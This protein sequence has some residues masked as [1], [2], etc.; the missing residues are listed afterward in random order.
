MAQMTRTPKRK[1]GSAKAA[2]KHLARSKAERGK[3]A[4]TRTAPRR[5]SAEAMLSE[6]RRRL[7]EIDDL[8]A[9]A[10]LLGWDQA[11]YMPSGGARARGRQSATLHR[12]AHEQLVDPAIGRLLDGLQS[13][14]DSLS[15]D[16]DDACLI[17]VARRDFE[18][19]IKVPSDYVA[20]ANA[21]GAASYDAWTRARPA[22]TS[23]P[24]GRSWSK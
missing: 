13:H 5:R 6:L 9:A 21:L 15:P 16:S 4:A 12:L 19:A 24:C 20:R 14:A 18:K 3:A 2:I 22:T 7:C 8:A 17:R 23:Q 10:D 1:A 11:T